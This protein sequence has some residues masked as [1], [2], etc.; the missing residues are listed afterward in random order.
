MA[1]LPAAPDLALV[2][3]NW[4]PAL[5]CPVKCVVGG[6]GISLSIAAASIVAKVVRDRLMERLSRRYPGYFWHTNAGYGTRA[7]ME[8]L[9]ALGPTRHHRASF[10]PVAQRLLIFAKGH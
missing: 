2:D 8:A 7:H 9:A 10:G 6:D 3:G 4:P 1:R 5:C